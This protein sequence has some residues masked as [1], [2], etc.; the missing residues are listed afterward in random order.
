[1]L[2]GSGLAG[3][4]EQPQRACQDEP[5]SVF[6][7]HVPERMTERERHPKRACYPRA[8][9]DVGHHRDRHRRDARFLDPVG[10]QDDRPAAVRSG[11]RQNDR[12]GVVFAQHRDDLRQVVDE[13]RAGVE[14]KA[15]ERVVP[16]GH[17]AYDAFAY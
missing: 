15:H 14:L 17:I 13:Q 4:F 9:R 1:M 3:P 2:D 12:V 6:V 7:A 5:V 16:P 10:D 11:R 8:L